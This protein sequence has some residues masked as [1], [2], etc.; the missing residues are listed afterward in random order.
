MQAIEQTGGAEP[1]PNERRKTFVGLFVFPMLIVVGMAALLSAIVLLTKEDETPE[2]LLNAVKTGAPSKRWQK[3]YELS[4]ELNSSER[5]IRS[6]GLMSEVVHVL[7]DEVHYD[8]KTRAYMAMALSRFRDPE[9]EEVLLEALR[10][11]EDAEEPELGLFLMW[12]LGNFKREEAA[13]DEI[14]KEVAR[15]LQSR[16]GDLRKGAAYIL[17]VLGNPVAVSALKAALGDEVD[18]VRWNA[19]LS[20]A[21]LGD[22]SGRGILL[23]M[24]DRERLNRPHALTDKSIERIM[25]NAAKGLQLISEKSG[26]TEEALRRVS[27]SDPNL[28]VRQAALAAFRKNE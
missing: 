8:A 13:R 27:V 24:L 9:A 20:L 21:R 25:V 5:L 7:N 1:V 3:A 26:E 19:A 6:A 22:S 23:S 28:K 17:G 16:Q 4:N 15:F 12:A 11:T 10:K 18:D 2:S 14:A